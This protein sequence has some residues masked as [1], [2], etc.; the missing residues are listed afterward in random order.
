MDQYRPE[1]RVLRKPEKYHAINRRTTSSE[2]AEALTIAREE[3]LYRID[4]RW[5]H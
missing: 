5:M 2:Y 3:G 1:G 4:Q